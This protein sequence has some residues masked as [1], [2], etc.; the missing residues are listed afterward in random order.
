MRWH[1]LPHDLFQA[2]VWYWWV[3]NLVALLEGSG[4]FGGGHSFHGY[5]VPSPFL[6]CSV[7]WLLRGVSTA[8][9]YHAFLPWHFYLATWLKLKGPADQASQLLKPWT[10]SIYFLLEVF[11]RYFVTG[12]RSWVDMVSLV[13]QCTCLN[14]PC[15][16]H[17]EP[18]QSL[19]S[20]IS[21]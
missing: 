8:S 12:M 19:H 10:K 1:N 2:C 15:E 9:L 14:P 4:L 16:S 18:L 20:V 17:W 5:L 6:Y 21:A 7:S 13:W 3:Q 11:L